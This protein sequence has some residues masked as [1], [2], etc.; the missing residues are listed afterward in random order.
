MLPFRNIVD[1]EA[2]CGLSS[3]S[4][5]SLEINN[6]LWAANHSLTDVMMSSFWVHWRNKL[7]CRNFPWVNRLSTVMKCRPVA[8]G[9]PCKLCIYSSQSSD[10]PAYATTNII[11]RIWHEIFTGQTYVY[12][13]LPL[14]GLDRWRPPT[15]QI[16][17]AGWAE[18]FHRR[19]SFPTDSFT[20]RKA[21]VYGRVLNQKVESI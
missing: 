18:L 12:L 2:S 8:H 21:K 5:S 19:I 15:V 17:A 10:S 11:P 9:R 1:L 16:Y 20:S 13:Y 7:N 14:G 4:S 3:S 6:Q